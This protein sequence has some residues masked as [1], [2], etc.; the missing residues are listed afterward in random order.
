MNRRELLGSLGIASASTLLAAFG[1]G[2]KQKQAGVSAAKAQAGEV[3]TWLRDAVGRLAAHYSVVHVLAVSRQYSVAAVD[4]LGSGIVHTH[5][6]GAV[7]RVREKTGIWREEVTADL[8]PAGLAAATR[9]LI[10]DSKQQLN[11]AIPR[12]PVASMGGRLDDKALHARVW[13][14]AELER[15]ESRIVYAA[16]AIELDDATVWSIAPDHDREQQLVRVRERA[17]RVAW[18]GSRAVT[19][20]AQRAYLGVG[21]RGLDATAVASATQQA[22]ELTTPGGF[23]DRKGSVLLDPSVTA[24]LVDAA[25]RA[26]LTATVAR[27]PEQRKRVV[28]GAQIASP[29]VTLV[30]DPTA[31]GAYGGFAFDDAGVVAARMPL[32]EAGQLVGTIGAGRTSR[33]GHVGSA[34]PA[35]SHLV[36]ARGPKPHGTLLDE[37]FMLELGTSATV[38]PS[39]TQVV[40]GASRAREIRGG[41]VTG[42]MYP[43][44]EL[45][46][47]LAALLA[48]VT[49]VS[50]N[51]AMFGF[52]DLHDGEPRWRSIEA[53]WLR[54]EGLL[55]RRA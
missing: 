9:Q 36:I 24:T 27:R 26:L 49:A 31:R 43:D 22:L 34:E 25:V 1:C 51:T 20:E 45:V 48:S 13:Q 3:R 6:E 53:P 10:G 37:G 46:G 40:I 30:D 11:I 5:R 55:R 14:L 42:R 33:A 16:S 8:S 35:P 21:Q 4:V 54:V 29:Q 38:D 17:L 23:T 28:I 2:G 15:P 18:H 44:V 19:G 52:R 50:A 32:V 12:V 41:K 39:S 7:L 47:E